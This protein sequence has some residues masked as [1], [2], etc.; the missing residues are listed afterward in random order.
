MPMIPTTYILGE[1][2]R[3]LQAP[4]DATEEWLERTEQEVNAAKSL[5]FTTEHGDE[6]VVTIAGAPI[7]PT[8]EFG[9][10][11]LGIWLAGMPGTGP[12]LEQRMGRAGEL[13][14]RVHGVQGGRARKA[15]AVATL[16]LAVSLFGAGLADAALADLRALE[17]RVLTSVW[18]SQRGGRAKE[19]VFA[20][21]MKGR[22]LSPIMKFN[23]MQVA[24]QVRVARR[25]GS[26]QTVVQAVWE[27]TSGQ[28]APTGPVGRVFHTLWS[29]GWKPLEGWWTSWSR[30]TWSA[31]RS[32]CRC[33]GSGSRYGGSS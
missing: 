29:L 31:T 23:C 7:S 18:G 1:E 22:R 13:L 25:P 30:T 12:L 16:V 2:M 33:T 8:K 32:C 11:G 9:C 19:V 24:W 20:V 27:D 3:V 21:L 14:S 26:L 6:T 10:L 5:V 15:E 4:L 17:T 28:P